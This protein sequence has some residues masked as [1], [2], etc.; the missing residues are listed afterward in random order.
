MYP[1]Y[2]VSRIQIKERS[3]M[4]RKSPLSLLFFLFST[5]L[6]LNSSININI[7]S[8]KVYPVQEND[9]SHPDLNNVLESI[10]TLS[11]FGSRVIGYEG[12]YR[13]A[14]YIADYWRSL[15]LEVRFE[16]FTATTPIVKRSS[17]KIELPDGK[18]IEGE[19]YPLWPNHVNPCPYT[20]PIEGD[21]LVYAKGGV[22]EDF[23]G[24]N[25]KDAFVL[26]DFNDR[27]YWKN[28]L[29]YGAKGVI[30]L[31]PED[32]VALQSLQKVFSVP[33]NF[34]R[35]YVTGQT[36]SLLKSLFEKNKEVKIWIDSQMEWESRVVSN[37]VAVVE[38][39][40]PNLKGEVAI[41]GAYYDSWSIVPQL[42]PGA[43]DSMGIS[44]LLEISRLLTINPPK[45]TIWL[46]AFAGHY[47][48]L[49]GAREFVEDHFS[50]LG[51]KIKMMLTLDIA[52]ESDVLA[53][54]ATG[55]TYGY[56]Q[57]STL[58]SRYAGWL[59]DI[60]VNWKPALEAELG[61]EFKLIDGVTWSYPSWIASSPPFEP[62]LR[63]FEAEVFTEACY[64]GAVG[65]VTTNAFRI[66]QYTPFDKYEK[67][68]PEKE[69]NLR[70][71]VTILWPILYNSANMEVNYFLA[72][73]RVATDWGLITVTLQLAQYDKQT[74]WFTDFQHKDAIFFVSVG[75]IMNPVGSVVVAGF[76]ASGG[77]GPSRSVVVQGV[78][79]GQFAAP[80]IQP[81]QAGAIGMLGSPLGFTTIVKPDSRGRVVLK[82]IKPLTGIDAQAYIIDPK[83][84]DIIYATDTGPFGAQKLRVGGL[85]GQQSAAAAP[86]LTAGTEALAY[87]A[88]SGQVARAFSIYSTKGFRYIPVFKTASICL[89]GIFDPLTIQEPM[90]GGAGMGLTVEAYNFISHSYFVWRDTLAPWPE[91]MIFIQPD[92]PA[93]VVVKSQGRIIAVLNNASREAPHGRGYMLKPGEILTLTLFDVVE[94]MYYL[95]DSRAGFLLSKM[96]ANPKLMMHLERMYKFRKLAD[97]AIKNQEAGKLYSYYIGLWQNA[98]RA[99][100]SSFSLIYDVVNTA[101]FFFFLSAAFIILIARLVSGRQTGPKRMA[102]ILA[103]FL[104]TNGIL[105]IVHPGY[106][107]SSNIWML[108]DGLAVI[109]FSFL[110]FY[111]VIGEFND[112]IKTI[113]KTVLG[114]HSSDIE[115]GSVVISALS[116]GIEN[117]R[118]R[119]LRTGLTLSTI[120]ITISA[121]T[122]F[123]TMGVMA[124]T[125]RSS[126]G[127]PPYSG[128]L[129]KRP[130]PDVM[131]ISISEVYLL[132]VKDIVAEG[133]GEFHT[134]PRA[135]IYP[136]GR[137]ILV[138]WSQSQNTSIAAILAITPEEAK[139]LEDAILPGQGT[140]F[141]P[142]IVN[143]MMISKS[144]AEKLS[145]DLGFEV[146]AGSKI[147]LYG[148]PVMVMGILD[149]N[150]GT[151]LLSKDLDLEPI[152]PLDRIGTSMSRRPVY[153]SLSQFIIVPY[154]F[155]KTYF[156]VQPNVISVRAAS[157]VTEEKMWKRALDMVLTLP[158]DVFYG[159][160]EEGVSSKVASRDI[161]AMS[162]LQTTMVPLLLSSLSILSMMLSS[163]YERRREIATLSTVGLSP[164]HIG[165]IFVMESVALA[166]IGSFLGYISGAGVTYA[167]WNL[168]LF[169]ADLIPNVSSGVVLIVMGVMMGATILSSIYPIMRAS[170]LATPSLLRKWRIESKPVG[171]L[172][173]ISLPFNATEEETL[174][175]L[176]FLREYFEASSTERTGLFMLL[177]PIEMIR[178]E[179]RRILRARLQLSP[180]DAGIIQD[181]DILSLQE[182][183]ERYRFEILIRRLMGVENLWITSNRALLNEVRKQ[184]L[185]WR[186]LSPDEKE[187]YIKE[188]KRIWEK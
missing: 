40:D 154:E 135:W 64:G 129:L 127:A 136:P 31:E 182:E 85:F 69:E 36:A 158:F 105:G 51:V 112:A 62:F 44:F 173:S 181:F 144:T 56:N 140:A 28:A 14:D 138:K 3:V 146:E 79:V 160:K 157:T 147:N 71:Q 68:T 119:P 161:Y 59:K 115:R 55:S 81:T 48:G 57:P 114:F 169:P 134:N 100:L 54:Y 125:Y 99:Y 37:I 2:E 66:Y 106:T 88:A 164:R 162:G 170:S 9:L 4:R 150:V 43:T 184:F 42:S 75:A 38:G 178:E 108:I 153:L 52:S 155:A 86:V 45:R 15:G 46:V 113:S 168:N 130:A 58:A 18:T 33:V 165:S 8:S 98:L 163:V 145:S 77:Q 93:E 176:N 174:G 61:E 141:A 17:I 179:R 60:F 111:V 50:E 89:V 149:D 171:N 122:I 172:W 183:A 116:M 19:A 180:F 65:F 47:E 151:S 12:F 148:I 72:P 87:L 25:A 159:V 73:K 83:T 67:I 103:L 123:T 107:I 175:I 74:D 90:P 133:I 102:I 78:T 84:G 142:K 187:R 101:T 120:I 70:K 96:S 109:L 156:N 11:S 24:I 104:I 22:P 139:M 41:I 80:P 131:D 35:L 177:K 110:L 124:L 13:A 95:A 27:W 167:L 39:T 29:L 6:I 188:A 94:N 30:F 1:V 32:T 143:A 53:V 92:I 121:M 20:S 126:L 26:M 137:Q 7:L 82:G 97:E 5:L 63:Y 166:F 185:L 10:R 16:N 118:K 186:A 21:R 76:S 152:S 128:I 132:G 23:Q 117:L 34:P 49:V 91:A